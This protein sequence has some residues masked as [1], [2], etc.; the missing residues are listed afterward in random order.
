MDRLLEISPS[1]FFKYAKSPHW[2][3]YDIHGDQSMKDELPEFTQKLIEGGM[4][5]EE[6]CVRDL[7][8]VTV[9]KY[10]SE[11]EAE[12]QTLNYMKAGKELIY[13]GVISYVKDNIKF[14]GRPDF[15]KKS[16]GS[17]NF[18]NYY[19]M[20]VEIKNSK[21]CDKAEYKKQ[22]MLYAII[23]EKIQGLRPNEGEFI[24]KNKEKI[25]CEL[26]QKILKD[27][28]DTVE[29]ILNIFNGEE[30]CLIV[31]KDAMSTPWGQV[32][33]EEAKRKSDISLLYK[34]NC[35]TLKGLKKEGVKT[36]KQMAECDINSLPKIKGAGAK[37]IERLKT[38]AISLVNNEIIPISKV[39]IPDSLTKIYFDIEGDPFLGIEYLFG[40]WIEKENVEPEFKYFLA[41]TPEDEEKMWN[42]FLRWLEIENFKDYKVYHYHFYEKV[43]LKELSKKY[44]VCTL[45]EEFIENLVDLSKELTNS[46]TFPVYFYSIKDIAKYLKFKWQHEKAGGAQS[47][48]WYE[49]WLETNDRGI[50]QD[51]I[52]YNEDDVRATEFLHRWLSNHT[53]EE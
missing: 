50:L 42:D 14:K 49:K 43:K 2:I 31:S 28:N 9:D 35:N 25:T 18:G 45:L 44:G 7:E 4:L 13:Q 5:H 11:E 39:E 22:L 23:L 41:E 8:K 26:T 12:K 32:I 33:L 6:E 52:N 51:I 27:T 17:S 20:P 30:P 19:Y 29:S 1:L 34:I 40:F 15:L 16:E 53:R 3:W 37:T 36:V 10:I 46:F 21:K 38:Q 47:I 24:N 48:F